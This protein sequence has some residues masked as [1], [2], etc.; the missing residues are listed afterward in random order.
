MTKKKAFRYYQICALAAMAVAVGVV[1]YALTELKQPAIATTDQT[2]IESFPKP[3]RE[4]YDSYRDQ[5]LEPA[6]R[7]CSDDHK[8]IY[9]VESK[10]GYTNITTYFNSFGYSMG[11]GY[12]DDLGVNKPGPVDEALYRCHDAIVPGDNA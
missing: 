10:S 8:Q 6:A 9:V 12:S 4:L 7:L 5:G 3:A 1:I 2:Y 11:E